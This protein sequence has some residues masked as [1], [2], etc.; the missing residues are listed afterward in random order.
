MN[1][2]NPLDILQLLYHFNKIFKDEV[3][4]SGPDS[5]YAGLEVESDGEEHM[6]IVSISYSTIPLFL[7]K[8]CP[9]PMDF[10]LS[11]RN[12]FDGDNSTFKTEYIKLGFTLYF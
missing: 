10:T 5:R 9:V 8:K 1:P 3:T 4:G 11:Y 12:K 2:R 6:Y 7:E